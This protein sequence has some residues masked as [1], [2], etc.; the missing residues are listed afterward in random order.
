M[1]CTDLHIE[2]YNHNKSFLNEI[3]SINGFEDWQVTIIFYAAIHYLESLIS[4]CYDDMLSGEKLI[5]G[6]K[7]HSY[8]HEDRREL[9]NMTNEFKGGSQ[10][11]VAY[12]S[13]QSNSRKARYECFKITN[14]T[15]QNAFK[16]LKQIEELKQL[17][18]KKQHQR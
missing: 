14:K 11:A 4:V 2:K 9:L 8:T 16:H 18:L 10:Y 6:F 7:G 17:T 13:L 3:S 15:L 1:P 5:P 12:N